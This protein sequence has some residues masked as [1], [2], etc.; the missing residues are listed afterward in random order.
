MYIHKPA[1]YQCPFC[2]F[3]L[4]P[5]SGNNLTIETDLVFQNQ[6]TTAFIGIRQWPNNSGNT[7]IIP[8]QHFE[9]I[10]DLP[11]EW[12]GRI[13]RLAKAVA[14]AMKQALHCDGI[15]LRQ[16]NEP[17]GNQDV[18]HYHVHVTPRYQGDNFYGAYMTSRYIMPA[19][20]R[21][22]LAGILRPLV[23]AQM[24]GKM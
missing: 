23:A 11:A 8:N 24:A 19:E 17:A 14:L 1:D 10:Y 6:F 9:N 7:I 20:E 13:H 22:K 4:S 2:L 12:A 5:S 15:S 18:W 3:V 21:A 16:H